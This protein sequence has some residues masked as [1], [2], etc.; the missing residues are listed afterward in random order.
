MRAIPEPIYF[1]G[2]PFRAMH[3]EAAVRWLIRSS[4]EGWTGHV[5]FLNAFSIVQA[6]ADAAYARTVRSPAVNFPDG[7]PLALLSP[8]RP[9]RLTQIRGPEFF[10]RTLD[11]GRQH[12]VRHFFLGSTEETLARLASEVARRYPGVEIVGTYSPPFRT[13]SSDEAN[14]QDAVVRAAKPD[15]VWLG[16]GTPKQDLEAQRLASV[17]PCPVVAIGAAFDF[18]AGTLRVAPHWVR[19]MGLEWA[20]RLLSEPRRL[21]RRYLLGNPKFLYLVLRDRL[22]AGGN[23]C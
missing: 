4:L 18:S 17:V 7:K 2:L 1:C 3:L 11:L 8:R 19:T 14:E 21:W 23:K 12:S 20:F 10:E 6:H 16:L 5:H 13:L 9:E 22:S 15:L